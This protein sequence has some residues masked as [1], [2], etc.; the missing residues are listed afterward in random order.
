MASKCIDINLTKDVKDFY[1][2]KYKAVKHEIAENTRRWEKPPMFMVGRIN[3]V[4]M[5]ALPK[6]I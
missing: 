1:N 2:E 4:K 6:V 5:A 3:F